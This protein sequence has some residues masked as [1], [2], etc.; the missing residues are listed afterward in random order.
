MEAKKA[1]ADAAKFQVF[2]PNTLAIE[3]A[4]KT[5][6]QKKLFPKT[7]LENIL[8]TSFEKLFAKKLL[9]KKLF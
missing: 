9:L 2:K 6:F 1:G 5:K 3:K 4:K 8:K 7:F